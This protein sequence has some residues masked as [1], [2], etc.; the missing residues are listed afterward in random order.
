M[1]TKLKRNVIIPENK[2]LALRELTCYL[3]QNK[4][5]KKHMLIMVVH[6]EI[7]YFD[8]NDVTYGTVDSFERYYNI[9][10]ELTATESIEI[11]GRN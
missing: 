2:P 9:I 1:R 11:F 5:T 3:V 6:K 8:E 4:D 7:I 10:R